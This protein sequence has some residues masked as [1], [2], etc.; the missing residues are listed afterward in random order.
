MGI[1]SVMAIIDGS[2][3]SRTTMRM[4]LGIGRTFD[5][6]T[7]LIQFHQ[8][9][10]PEM[11][12]NESHPRH[13]LNDML[14]NMQRNAEDRRRRFDDF[15]NE[16]VLS[17]GL[18]TPPHDTGAIRLPGGFSVSKEI[19]CGHE[20]REI[21]RRGRL[22]DLTIISS[23]GDTLGHGFDTATEA[24]LLETGRPVLIVPNTADWQD[25]DRVII[26]WD[27]S[28]EAAKS[29]HAALP[30]LRRATS[31]DVIHVGDDPAIEPA[32]VCRYLLSHRIGA[33][34]QRLAGYRHVAN[35]LIDAACKNDRS[36]LV[37]GAAGENTP[38][39]C[40]YGGTVRA[41]VDGAQTPIFVSH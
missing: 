13:R 41:A 37:I 12:F 28:A 16:D 40:A 20:N 19:V 18:P 30:F 24:A 4:A 14:N 9:H 2:D 15:F 38:P 36:M 29:I 34:A 21:A 1:A 25:C 32:D 23:P 11:A 5:A 22:F 3:D 27:G 33:T 35:A 31:V 39:D 17:A 6:A 8:P 7:T 26:A 10:V